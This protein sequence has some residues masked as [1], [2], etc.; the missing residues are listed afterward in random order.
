M[1]EITLEVYLQT[2][3]KQYNIKTNA[4]KM[5]AINY[6]NMLADSRGC[7]GFRLSTKELVYPIVGKSALGSHF[8]DIDDNEYLDMAMG[9][10]CL[11]FGH[12]PNFLTTAIKQHLANGIQLGPQ[13]DDIHAIVKLLHEITSFSRFAF[14]NSGTEAIMM[15]CRLARLYSKR[16]KII[17]F[18]N[19]YHGSYDGTI[20]FKP[21]DKIEALPFYKGLL[22]S[23]YQDILIL[24]Y[25]EIDIMEKL[26]PFRDQIA[27][28]LVEPV[29]SREPASYSKQFLQNLRIICSE[30][31]C[32]LIF[33]EV[34]T[35]F[36]SHLGGATKF[37]N[38]TPDLVVYGK[39]IASGMPV[40]VLG[41]T[42]NI[43]SGVDGGSWSYDDK[44]FP[45]E[46]AT[47]FGGT[48]N[49]NPMTCC[50]LKATLTQLKNEGTTNIIQLN[51]NTT[52]LASTLN[53]FFSIH[54]LPLKV[55]YF[56]SL[57]KIESHQNI[58]IFFYHLIYYGIYV[59]EG[60][61]LF[62]STAHSQEDIEYFIAT[63]KTA[64]I[65]LMKTGYFKTHMDTVPKYPLTTPSSCN[66]MDPTAV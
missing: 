57:F 44:S 1:S 66:G 12:Y 11:L 16:A 55:N 53:K 35:G 47:F 36:R 38:I 31:K 54:N 63:V 6:R 59:W 62:L 32:V 26:Y 40:G 19:S 58:D 5:R 8:K 29:R 60:R 23:H 30:L 7:A 43:M 27:A 51:K 37:F 39:V 9:F 33:D 14:C 65:T 18:T 20:G 21:T 56:A 64:T 24:E 50:A 28:I 49:K 2:F 34:I 61:T 17:M 22:S 13:A 25:G 45:K 48:F 3:I 52:Y 41:G 42:E 4:S 10:G 15:A 46:E